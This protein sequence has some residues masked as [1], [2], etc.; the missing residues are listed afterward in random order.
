MGR[1]SFN[2][3]PNASTVPDLP[4]ITV[5]GECMH[6]YFTIA[7]TC[8]IIISLY[9]GCISVRFIL[10]ALFG[11]SLGL[12]NETNGL[13]GVLYGI[14]IIVFGTFTSCYDFVNMNI[15]HIECNH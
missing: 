11:L 6:F 9:D 15:K 14:N 13:K 8:L 2:S 5:W 7:Y 12:R 3:K 1:L 10:G 4:E